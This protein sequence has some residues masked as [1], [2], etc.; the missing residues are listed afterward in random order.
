LLFEMGHPGGV[1][2]EGVQLETP[3]WAVCAS[4]TGSAALVF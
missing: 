1:A 4:N 2:G 3:G